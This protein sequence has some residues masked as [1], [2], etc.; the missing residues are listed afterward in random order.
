MVE[1]V[2][3]EV[4][5]GLPPGRTSTVQGPRQRLS[6]LPPSRCS[7]GALLQLNTDWHHF[8]GNLGRPADRRRGRADVGD[9]ERGRCARHG[10][11]PRAA[12]AGDF[13][14]EQQ[15]ATPAK[16]DFTFAG[17]AK[18]GGAGRGGGLGDRVVVQVGHGVAEV[19]R[20]PSSTPSADASVTYRSAWTK[21]CKHASTWLLGVR[22]GSLRVRE[23]CVS[24]LP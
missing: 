14:A 16:G 23:H 13:A 10:D 1:E 2:G 21:R 3:A 20:T 6:W 7:T 8:V 17:T 11:L 5:S 22:H 18:K 12:G 15:T 4:R 24:E 19:E 9:G